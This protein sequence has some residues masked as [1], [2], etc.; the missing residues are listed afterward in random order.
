MLVETEE[1]EKEQQP[2]KMKNSG[3]ECLTTFPLSNFGHFL[4]FDHWY[5]FMKTD[6][7]LSAYCHG[8]ADLQMYG[9]DTGQPACLCDLAE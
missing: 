3:N 4:S 8:N 7:G 2:H 9:S 5:P 1:E 6:S